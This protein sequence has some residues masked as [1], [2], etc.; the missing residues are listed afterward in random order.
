M[1][2]HADPG[3]ARSTKMQEHAGCERG[4]TEP[5][6]PPQMYLH[7]LFT[8]NSQAHRLCLR[9]KRGRRV[10]RLP[11][12]LPIED[13][14][15]ALDTLEANSLNTFHKQQGGVCSTDMPLDTSN[16]VIC[17]AKQALIVIGQVLPKMPSV[18]GL[19]SPSGQYAPA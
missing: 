12:R 19:P 6:P 7:G 2:E 15:K 9:V 18:R 1:Q 10:K 3:D 16:G 13:S 14:W 5:P 8:N 11:K 4:N 17:Q